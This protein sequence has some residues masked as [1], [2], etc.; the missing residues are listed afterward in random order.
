MNQVEVVNIMF[1]SIKEDNRDL[2]RRAGMPDDVIEQQIAQ[3]EEGLRFMLSNV[4]DKL[5]SLN[6]IN[7]N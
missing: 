7:E 4:Y 1:E 2:A 6:I 5:K 3:S